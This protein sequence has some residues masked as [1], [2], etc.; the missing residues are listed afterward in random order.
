VSLIRI[1][2]A[3]PKSDRVEGRR[4]PDEVLGIKGGASPWGNSTWKRLRSCPREHALA[5]VAGIRSMSDSEALTQGIIFHHALEA[6]Y[7]YIQQHQRPYDAMKRKTDGFL[8]GGIP[9][10]EGFA[11]KAIKPFIAEDGY[12]KTYTAI[13]RMLAS[14]FDT[15]RRQDRWRIIAVEETLQYAD[16]GMIYSARLDLI[17][18]DYD[19]RGMWIVEHK[20]AKAITDT[21][22][23]GY[24]LDQQILGQ[25]WLLTRCVDLSK[26]PKLRGVLVNITTKTATPKHERVEVMPSRYHLDEFERSMRSWYDIMPVFEELGWPKALGNCAGPAQYFSKCDYFDLCYGRPEATVEELSGADDALP[27]GYM[28][29]AEKGT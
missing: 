12:S 23:S 15:F 4:R 7:R 3:P 2:I 28:R 1:P 22:L 21:L 5:V 11:W 27:F 26:Y 6:F 17:V 8:Y 16:D 18:E 19:R 20:S 13:E 25:A 29:R 24:Q 14:Y 9:D 10:A